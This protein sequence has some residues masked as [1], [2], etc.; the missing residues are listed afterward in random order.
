MSALLERFARRIPPRYYEAVIG[1]GILL[2]CGSFLAALNTL[3]L[4]YSVFS[5]LTGIH[6]DVHAWGG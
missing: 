2:V 4:L 6:I 1:I 3:W 5:R